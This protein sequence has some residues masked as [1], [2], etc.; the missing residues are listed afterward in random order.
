MTLTQAADRINKSG[1]AVSAT[2]LETNG[3]AY[4]SI[5]RRDTGFVVGKPGSSALQ[6]TETSTGSLGQALG[7]TIQESAV[8]AQLTVDG[9]AFERRSNVVSDVIPGATLTLKTKPGTAE[10]MLLTTSTR[11]NQK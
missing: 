7:A 5:T 11:D 1:I 2:V 10:D 8:N 3:A 6:I 9:L 4:L